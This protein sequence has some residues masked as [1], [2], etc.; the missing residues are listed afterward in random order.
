MTTSDKA[1][2]ANYTV[3]YGKPPV[4]TRFPKGKSGNAGGKEPGRKN[5]KAEVLAELGE[6][7]AVMKNG[8]RKYLSTQTIIVKRMVSDAAKGDPKARDQLLKVISLIESVQP[9]AEPN[10]MG[11]AKDDEILARFKAELVAQIREGTE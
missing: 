6:R 7:V 3:G 8:R 5:F 1:D 10:P 9:T 11:T 2:N 4:H